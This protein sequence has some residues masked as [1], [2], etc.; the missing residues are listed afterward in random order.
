[1]KPGNVAHSAGMSFVFGALT[2][3][4]FQD[5]ALILQHHV[6]ENS[7]PCVFAKTQQLGKLSLSLCV[8]PPF[9]LKS[10][11]PIEENSA[12]SDEEKK[13]EPLKTKRLKEYTIQSLC[14]MPQNNT[15]ANFERFA[16]V[17]EDVSLME[18][19]VSKVAE[20]HCALQGDMEALLSI[21]TGKEAWYKEESES[22]RKNLSQVRYEFR[23]VEAQRR[24]LQEDLRDIDTGLG[25][26]SGRYSQRQSQLDSLRLELDAELQWLQEMMSSLHS[27]GSGG[28]LSLNADVKQALSELLHHSCRAELHP[29]ARHKLTESG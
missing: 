18:M 28:V 27:Q 21:Y 4:G 22:A 19:A 6:L 5:H 9:G 17:V 2:C 14:S 24:Q 23:K 13:A 29:E 26:V 25:S 7:P 20:A 8:P 16:H 11:G 1:M 10:R 3:Y 15:Y 12:P